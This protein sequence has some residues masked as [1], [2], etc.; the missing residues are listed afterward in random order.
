MSWFTP[1]TDQ[2]V[3]SPSWKTPDSDLVST[4]A[5]KTPLTDS[6]PSITLPEKTN[7]NDLFEKG[8]ELFSPILG[9]TQKQ[10]VNE[11]VGGK[12][13]PLGSNVEQ[14]GLVGAAFA[15]DKSIPWS[16]PEVKKEPLTP[17]K[18]GA[19]LRGAGTMPVPPYSISFTALRTSCMV[20][21]T[22]RRAFAV[23]A[24]RMSQTICGFF[25]KGR[26]R[27]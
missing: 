17:T 16:L 22:T 20:V 19:A 14:Q 2:V 12:Y 11:S 23:P 9:P 6:E 7:L 1:D 21:S 3:D 13:R 10:R 15:P 4:K 24:S 26:R 25:S 18:W 27:S 8:R 5:W